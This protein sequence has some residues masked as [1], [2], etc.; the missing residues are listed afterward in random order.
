MNKEIWNHRVHFGP[1]QFINLVI[2]F[3]G[4]WIQLKN[5]LKLSNHFFYLNDQNKIFCF[6]KQFI[7]LF[8]YLILTIW[9]IDLFLYILPCFQNVLDPFKSALAPKK[10]FRFENNWRFCFKKW[11]DVFGCIFL[12]LLYNLPELLFRNHFTFVLF[13]YLTWCQIFHLIF[14]QLLNSP[15]NRV[16]T[17][18]TFDFDSTLVSVSFF[19]AYLLEKLVKLIFF[20]FCFFWFFDDKFLQYFVCIFTILKLNNLILF[21]SYCYVIE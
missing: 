9:L 13:V 17:F 7:L 11:F 19:I 15:E 21:L 2:K 5:Q 1:F 18:C 8:N 14:N 3:I 20:S 12:F 6:S 10:I 16:F 4:G